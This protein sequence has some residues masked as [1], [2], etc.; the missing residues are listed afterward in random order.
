M[1]YFTNW[2]ITFTMCLSTGLFFFF[3]NNEVT[4]SLSSSLILF[5]KAIPLFGTGS[6]SSPGSPHHWFCLSCPPSLEYAW[7]PPL[8]LIA[9]LPRHLLLCVIVSDT[10]L[11][12]LNPFLW[13]CILAGFISPSPPDST[14]MNSDCLSVSLH[15]ICTFT[16]S[17][18]TFNFPSVY[19][20]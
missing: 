6:W 16:L 1:V 9:P 20:N 11:I 8:S 17:N 3:L 19:H 18:E 13:G 7:T 5:A 4:T 12:M 14:L 15:F 10:V 2:S